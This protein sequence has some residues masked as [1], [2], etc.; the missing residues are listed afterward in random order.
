MASILRQDL[1]ASLTDSALETAIAS[2]ASNYRAQWPEGS[3]KDTSDP[4]LFRQFRG[5]IMRYMVRRLNRKNLRNATYS[6]ADA[7][8]I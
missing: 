1:L 5:E 2:V 4:Q 8:R 7:G 3:I 6:L